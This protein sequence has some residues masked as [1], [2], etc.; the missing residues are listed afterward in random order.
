MFTRVRVLAV[1]LLFVLAAALR[2]QTS[3]PPIA[4]VASPRDH[5]GAAIGDDYFLATYAQLES[6][7]TALAG[8]SSR[9]RLIDIGPTEEGRRQWMAVVSAPENLESLDR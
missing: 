6:Y 1:V 8:Q 3:L 7:W 9:L 4:E 2:A 5:F